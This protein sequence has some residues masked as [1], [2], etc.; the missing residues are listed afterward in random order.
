MGDFLE[1]SLLIAWTRGLSELA[2]FL[3]KGVASS[4]MRFSSYIYLSS[5]LIFSH[6]IIVDLQR[7]LLFQELHSRH[8]TNFV[9]FVLLLRLSPFME[10]ST[11]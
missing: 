3:D 8:L 6:F 7:V 1:W 9:A 2:L 11:W 10:P 5:F 4:S